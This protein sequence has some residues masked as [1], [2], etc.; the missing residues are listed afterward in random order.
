[1]F[2]KEWVHRFSLFTVFLICGLLVFL[3]FSHFRPM[4]PRD[5]DIPARIGAIIV[6]LTAA[7]L[8]R[9]SEGLERY[10][11][12]FFAFFA[13]SFAQILD[14]YLSYWSLHLLRLDI[15]TPVGNAADK[16]ESTLLVVIPIIVLTKLSGNDM[17]SIYFKKGNLKLWLFIGVVAFL[18]IAIVSIPWAEWQFQGRDLS[19]ERVIPWV[20]WILLFVF[21]NAINEE[22]LFR[23]LFLRKLEPFLGAFSSNLLIAILFTLLHVGV[24]YT[25]DTLMFLAFLLLLGLALGY[26]TQKTDSIWG[27]VLIHAGVDIPVVVGLFSTLT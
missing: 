12:V 25:A 21:A 1:M 10:W 23:G 22:L 13:A 27:S 17:A 16:L 24:D 14:L 11:L 15:N 20:P 2:K 7:L 4:L 5:I 26:V 3:V 18:V 19:L 6:F 9:R 8:T